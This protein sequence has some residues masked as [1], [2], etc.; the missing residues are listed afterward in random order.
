MGRESRMTQVVRDEVR[1]KFAQDFGF[2]RSALVA[3]PFIQ[4]FKFC[5]SVMKGTV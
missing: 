2:F 4:R 1:E 3:M 5:L